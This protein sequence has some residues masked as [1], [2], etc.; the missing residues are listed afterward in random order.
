MRPK[1]HCRTIYKG[2]NIGIILYIIFIT[3]EIGVRVCMCNLYLINVHRRITNHH[4]RRTI[5]ATIDITNT[6]KSTNIDSRMVMMS[7][8]N[9]LFYLICFRHLIIQV[10][11]P[12]LIDWI[13]ILVSPILIIPINGIRSFKTATIEFTDDNR[14]TTCRI[15]FN[16]Y[17]NTAIKPSTRLITT[18]HAT[19]FTACQRQADIVTHISIS[20][21]GIDFVNP[22]VRHTA[23]DN[24][25]TALHFSILAATVDISNI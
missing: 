20:C 2:R 9:T 3:F 21:S 23:Q 17:L 11:R 10:L 15:F 22:V 25:C 7:A 19:E 16:V 5:A 4:G 6:R 13:A 1:F 8:I 18:K 24:L 14:Y 12:R